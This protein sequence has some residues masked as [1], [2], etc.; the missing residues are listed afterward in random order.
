MVLTILIVH[1]I[2]SKSSGEPA[3]SDGSARYWIIIRGL[4]RW[5][6]NAESVDKWD[7][8][9]GIFPVYGPVKAGKSTF[10]AF[11][12][13]ENFLAERA[14][15]MTSSPIWIK[16]VDDGPWGVRLNIPQQNGSWL[17]GLWLSTQLTSYRASS[18]EWICT[19]S[20]LVTWRE[21]Q[22]LLSPKVH[23]KNLLQFQ[24]KS[25][26]SPCLTWIQQ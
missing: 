3:P 25:K 5:H 20:S 13:R 26:D 7:L 21:R 2:P 4:W 9:E 18:H 12:L 6:H 10:L 11:L 17:L 1:I 23:E 15:P 8:A 16:H 14:L 19:G 24:K 22:V